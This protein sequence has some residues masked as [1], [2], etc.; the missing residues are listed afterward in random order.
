MSKGVPPLIDIVDRWVKW[1]KAKATK[2][3][4]VWESAGQTKKL[5]TGTSRKDLFSE[6]VQRY[7]SP[8][9]SLDAMIHIIVFP[10]QSI[11]SSKR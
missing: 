7:P 4:M 2:G 10:L 9:T 3:R 5:L 8:R 1:A 6:T 11:G